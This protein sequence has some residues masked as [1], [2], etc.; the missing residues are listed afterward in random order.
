MAT[1]VGIKIAARSGAAPEN[2]KRVHRPH[3]HARSEMKLKKQ[4]AWF[5][6]SI[7]D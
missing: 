1:L 4:D 5:R 3:D 2:R 6:V 7:I